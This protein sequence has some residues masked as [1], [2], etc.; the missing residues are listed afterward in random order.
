MTDDTD[1]RRD[2]FRYDPDKNALAE[3]ELDNEDAIMGLMRDESYS[4]GCVVYQKSAFD[5]QEGDIVTLKA[6][7]QGPMEAE[8][9][10]VEDVD[11]KLVKIG[12]E[13]NN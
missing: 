4:G 11:E 12:Y 1:N 10:W 3:I 13:W 5:F 8:I 7:R 6:G 9:K 2:Y